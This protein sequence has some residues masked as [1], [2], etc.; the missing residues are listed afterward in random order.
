MCDSMASIFLENPW[1]EFPWK[2]A[3]VDVLYIEFGVTNV[4]TP[5]SGFLDT[6]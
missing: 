5:N 2:Q 4:V 6:T 3:L 1:E